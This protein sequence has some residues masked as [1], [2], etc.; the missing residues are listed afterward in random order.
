MVK[1]V[2]TI[3]NDFVTE[4]IEIFSNLLLRMIFYSLPQGANSYQQ[5]S[6]TRSEVQMVE[7]I[8]DYNFVFSKEKFYH[9]SGSL[10]QQK[11]DYFI[12][13]AC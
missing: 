6:Y 7:H 3:L 4:S 10:I 12:K 11:R 13:I 1:G 8:S 9:F 5:V 2:N